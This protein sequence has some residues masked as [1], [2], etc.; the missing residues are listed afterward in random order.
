MPKTKEQKIEALN[1]TKD[2]LKKSQSVV[3]LEYSG[4]SVNDFNELRQ[5]L[6][7]VGAKV[8]VTK[9][10]LL[11]KA[12]KEITNLQGQTAVLYGFE[13]LVEP[14][15]VLYE[16]K[17]THQNKPEIKLGM[18]QGKL[19]LKEDIKQ[20]SKMPSIPELQAK[21]VGSMQAPIYGFVAI[22]SGVYT[23]FVRALNA[24]KNSK[25]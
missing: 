15:K 19:V 21:L 12:V 24:Y 6:A 5:K 16:F 25:S 7:Q 3:F 14:I 13:K 11:K 23:G 9:N 22:S 20:I 2:F 10:T 18:L 4:I 8:V 17:K 1:Q